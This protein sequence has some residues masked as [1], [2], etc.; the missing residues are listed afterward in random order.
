[1]MS[2]NE[3]LGDSVTH[4]YKTG[5]VLRNPDAH[6]LRLRNILPVQGPNSTRVEYDIWYDMNDASRVHGYVYTDAMGK[7]IYLRV[8][9]ANR[10]HDLMREAA[11]SP[12][13]DEGRAIF[14]DLANS[15]RDKYRLRHTLET[16]DK[17]A[18]LAGAN[19]L[20]KAVD[21]GKLDRIVQ[22]G[23]KLKCHPLTSRDL[24]QLLIKRFGED[25]II[26]KR[27][28]GYALL[29]AAREIA[30]AE[31]SEM[32]IVGVAKGKTLE[33]IGCGNRQLTY[34][35]IY[36]Q[37]HAASDK[38]DALLRILSC[39]YSGLVPACLSDPERRVELFFDHYKDIPH[40]KPKNRSY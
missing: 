3:S 39:P 13:T 5:G 10:T 27:V 28:S 14:E 11:Q 26:D 30:C 19:I 6:L 23:W 37:L 32:G 18:F 33:S 25:A 40:V 1:M 8:G 15:S 4:F 36:A 2:T 38:R 12:I 34:S 9:D 16:Y 24:R 21:W 7:F 35:A 31:N 29:D 17:V 22:D 20:N